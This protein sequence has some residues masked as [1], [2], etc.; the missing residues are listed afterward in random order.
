MTR[1]VL[2]LLRVAA[3]A[4]A[5]TVVGCLVVRRQNAANSS[6]SQSSGDKPPAPGKEESDEFINY[7]EPIKTKG[8]TPSRP[9]TVILG[10]KSAAVVSP[11]DVSDA[12][13]EPPP[14]PPQPPAIP[15]TIAPGNFAP[16]S[17]AGPP[18]RASDIR[19]FRQGAAPAQQQTAPPSQQ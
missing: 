7:G 8:V 14:A 10:T 17:K 5:L 16:S 12:R 3:I 4:S 11:R 6:A 18:V 2:I 15:L 1:P 9:E 19:Q 13:P